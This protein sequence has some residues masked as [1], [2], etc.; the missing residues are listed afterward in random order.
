MRDAGVTAVH[1]ADSNNALCSG[2]APVRLMLNEGLRVAL[3]SDVA[4][5]GTVRMFDVVAD[6]IKASKN[7]RILDGWDT[8]FLTVAE[9]WYL[10][11]SAGARFFGASPGFTPGELLH[12][13]VLSDDDLT[14]PT[15]PLSVRERFERCVYVRQRDAIRAVWSEGKK[16]FSA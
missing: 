9:G 16:I 6:T 11:T 14:P 13:L 1:C 10:G 7:R 4:G 8:D 12:A 15:R 2:V 5:G 3:G